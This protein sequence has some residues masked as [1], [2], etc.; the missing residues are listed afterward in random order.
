VPIVTLLE[1]LYANLSPKL[2][3]LHIQALCEGL[4]VAVRV[5]EIINRGWIRVNVSGEDEVAAF[6]LI[7]KEFGIAPIHAKNVQEGNVYRGK[8]VFSGK[9]DMEVYVDIGVSLPTPMDATVSLQHLKAQLVD[10]R[11]LP[12]KRINGLFCFLDNLPIEIL[13]KRLDD[14]R[15]CFVAEM[16]ERQTSL[17]LQWVH[18][19]LDRLVVL[20]AL[21]GNVENAV[22]ASGHLRDVAEIESL[23]MLEHAIV[24]KLGTD[25]RGLIPTIGRLL[26]HAVFGVFSPKEIS[27]FVKI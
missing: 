10:G 25:A 7:E 1:K 22:K 2:I 18:S 23:G 11:K 15:K 17:V 5:V 16:S 13:I 3:E 26:P 27:R 20:G 9:S 12:L 4:K 24:C 21:F 19:N 14:K 6:S 8:I